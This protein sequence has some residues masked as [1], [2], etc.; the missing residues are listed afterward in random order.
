MGLRIVRHYLIED[1]FSLISLR[2]RTH[3]KTFLDAFSQTMRNSHHSQKSMACTKDADCGLGLC[4]RYAAS[5]GANDLSGTCATPLG[6]CNYDSDCK[7]SAGCVNGQCYAFNPR[8]A[9]GTGTI[10][11]APLCAPGVAAT[12]DCFCA[13]GPLV[14]DN[15]PHDSFQVSIASCAKGNTCLLSGTNN[16]GECQTG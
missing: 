5:K 9:P 7:G 4:D 13:A 2:G 16:F 14:G 6:S 10:Q 15:A 8:F 12:Q 3:Y 1:H 11:H